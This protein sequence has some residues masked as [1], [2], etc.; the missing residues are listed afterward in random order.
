MGKK[1]SHGG[2]K[3]VRPWEG[4]GCRKILV[5][6]RSVA[7]QRY[8]VASQRF[9]TSLTTKSRLSDYDLVVRLL[10]YIV[11]NILTTKSRL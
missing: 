2:K 10:D 8:G 9:F 7:S 3:L 4:G 5:N 11:N 6:L 1:T